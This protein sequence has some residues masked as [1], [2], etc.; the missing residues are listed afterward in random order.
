M[1][2]VALGAL[3]SWA[4]A[5]GLVLAFMAGAAPPCS[6]PVPFAAWMQGERCERHPEYETEIGR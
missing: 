1:I 4:V 6:C 5:T 3:A 2:I